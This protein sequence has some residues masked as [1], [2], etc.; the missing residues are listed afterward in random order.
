MRTFAA[1]A[2][3]AFAAQASAQAVVTSPAPERV[4]VTVYRDPDRG[5][6]PLNLGWLGG[7]ALVSETRRVRLPAGTSEL[8]FEGV[9]SGIV[10]QSAIVTGLGE[11]VLEKNRDARLLSPGGLLD[12]SLGER[13]LLR[14]TSKATG[15]V[16]EQDAIVR[17]TGNGV[18]I[19]SADGIEALRCTGIPETLIAHSVPVGLSAKPTLSVRVRSPEPVERDV[20]LSYITNNFDWQA[21]Y[22]GEL[23]PSGDQMKLFAWMTL[24]NGDRTGLVDAQTQAVAGKLNRR[25]VWVDP[26]EAKPITISCWPQGT[27]SDIDEGPRAID[28]E[29]IMVTGTRLRAVAAPPPPPP[30]PAAPERDSGV[31]AQEERLGDVRL[32]RVPIEVTVAARSQKQ[33]AL[34]EQPAVR[35]STLLRLRPYATNFDLP[36]ERVLVTRNR[37]AEGLGLP[38]PAGKLALFGT[39]D[40]HRILIGEG[41]IDDRAVGEKVEIAVATPTGVRAHQVVT[42]RSDGTA[43]EHL[44]LTSDLSRPQQV[45]I[46]L[47][48]SAQAE[49]ERLIVRDGW[50]VWR[51]IIPANGKVELKYRWN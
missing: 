43:D 13:L 37:A 32:Y 1:F 29:E 23:S 35:V 46:E 49:G 42:R 22:V 40:G 31:M 19:Q 9:T 25:R 2:A 14:R 10:P 12:A 5:L 50:K 6:Q 8:R 51:P 16:R 20:T 27:T 28:A 45:E 41:T 24:A 30:P 47:P 26:G 38:L 7:Y 18:V 39:R 36:L 3:A 4:A 44:T 21:N 11:A 33:I 17:A 48:L 34:L 15:K